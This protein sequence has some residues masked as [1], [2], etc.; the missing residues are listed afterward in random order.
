MI[1]VSDGL[2]LK[3]AESYTVDI[4]VKTSVPLWPEVVHPNHCETTS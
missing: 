3:D 2:L 1:K 4:K